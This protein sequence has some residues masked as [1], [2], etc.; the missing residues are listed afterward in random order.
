MLI[1]EARVPRTAVVPADPP[2][3]LSTEMSGGSQHL[4]C[5]FLLPK[6]SCKG[7]GVGLLHPLLLGLAPWGCSGDRWSLGTD[8]NLGWVVGRCPGSSLAREK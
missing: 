6:V 1:V 8:E 3:E 2:P 7:W 5:S 4:I